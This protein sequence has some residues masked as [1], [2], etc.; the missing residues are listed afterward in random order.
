[1]G[2]LFTVI[3]RLRA[4]FDTDR[5]EKGELSMTTCGRICAGSL[6]RCILRQMPPARL[7]CCA[8]LG[9]AALS[10]TGCTLYPPKNPPTLGTTTS[11]EQTQRIFWKEV[12]SGEWN[13]VEALLAPNAVW[14][15]GSS[16]LDRASIVP[17][18]R[19]L[20]ITQVMVNG[21]VIK[22]NVNDMTLVYSLQIAAAQPAV[23]S[24][25]DAGGPQGSPAQ[26]GGAQP[27]NLQAV[28]VWQQPQPT[29][30]AAKD[31]HSGG[32]LLTVQ[33]L[34]PASMSG[35]SNLQGQG[36]NFQGANLPGANFAGA[37]F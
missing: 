7:L 36:T 37:N 3:D 14:R 23:S 6:T 15:N 26:A 31:T 17:W 29:A 32:F 22:S 21:V 9:A 33:D 11:A 18:L 20:H 13:G 12:E 19:S 24:T 2:T 30:N 34:T 10:L 4:N 27:Q 5:F 28:A 8:L 35:Q 1:M 25:A 16:V